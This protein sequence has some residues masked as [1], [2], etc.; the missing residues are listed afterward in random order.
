MQHPRHI[1]G[2]VA[3]EIQHGVRHVL[4]RAHA[5]HGHMAE[6]GEQKA[7]RHVAQGGIGGDESGQNGVAADVVAR[8]LQGDVLCQRVHGGLGKGIGQAAH[9]RHQGTDAGNVDDGAAAGIL[10]EGHGP[11]AGKVDALDIGAH[12]AEK[13][14]RVAFQKVSVAGGIGG[15]VVVDQNV[16]PSGPAC[17][18]V[19]EA[20]VIFRPC[21]VEA[22]EKGS[23]ALPP[24]GGDRLFALLFIPRRHKYRGSVPDKDACAGKAYAPAARRD[25]GRSSVQIRHVFFLLLR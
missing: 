8:V 11:P 4:R 21:G 17:G 14:L 6:K 12:D 18:R 10:H 20:G 19:D 25:Y 16:Q 15:A 2:G 13:G 24:H 23:A 7:L 1:G 3:C 22:E 9:I 5:A